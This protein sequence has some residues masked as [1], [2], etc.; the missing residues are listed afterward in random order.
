MNKLLNKLIDELSNGLESV[1]SEVQSY[2]KVIVNCF[3]DY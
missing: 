1:V 2:E 3:R